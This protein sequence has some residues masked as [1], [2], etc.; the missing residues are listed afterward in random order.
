LK[1]TTIPNL[2]C[3]LRKFFDKIPERKKEK[4]KPIFVLICIFIF[5]MVLHWDTSTIIKN[6]E[7][8]VLQMI[9]NLHQ[10]QT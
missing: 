10:A 7:G 6:N 1:F 9:S 4:K 2:C 3:S 5:I 8:V